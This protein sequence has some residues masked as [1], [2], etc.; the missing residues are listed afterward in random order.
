MPIYL[1]RFHCCTDGWGSCSH[2]SSCYRM[3]GWFASWELKWVCW[4]CDNRKC[5][6]LLA[7]EMFWS[8]FAMVRYFDAKRATSLLVGWS[9][10]DTA[11]DLLKENQNSTVRD[12]LSKRQIVKSVLVPLL[13]FTVQ[14]MYGSA[15]VFCTTDG[16][17]AI[18]YFC[19]VKYQYT[20]QYL[21]FTST[22]VHV[23]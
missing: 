4:F 19:R 2:I 12:T 20:V 9:S 6:W 18:L 8:P 1:N 17:L 5:A 3:F 13:Q 16:C 14:Y 7:Q 22:I 10:R 15:V 23:L 11:V 21:L